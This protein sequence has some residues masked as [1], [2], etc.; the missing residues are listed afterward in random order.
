MTYIYKTGRIEL[1]EQIKRHK[2]AIKGRVLDVGAGSFPRYKD[3]FKYDGY[4][5]MDIKEG[6]GIDAV[7]KI[8]AIPFPD[9]SFDSI[10]C[11]QV[12]GDVFE[13][14]KAFSELYR[15]LTVGGVLLITES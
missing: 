3:L 2:D 14:S 1:R 4:V 13:L 5:A 7:G 11:T 12:L 10:I 6:K 15:V 8:E 9:E